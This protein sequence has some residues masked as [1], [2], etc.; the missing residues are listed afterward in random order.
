MSYLPEGC[1]RPDAATLEAFWQAARQQLSNAG[2]PNDYEVRW[3]G[4]DA[5]STTEI[6]ELI[7]AGDKTGTFTLPWIVARTDQPTPQV[8]AAIILIDFD[9][10]PTLLIRLTEIVEVPF[11][12]ITAEHTAVDGT[13]VRSLSVWKPMHTQYWN[14]MLSPF[15]MTVDDDMPVWIEKFE[16]LYP[17][18]T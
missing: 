8:G 9:G 2:L 10:Q 3:I 18:S 7:R 6:L 15:A 5:E 1:A 12:E 11:G 17:E 13:P 14:A 4:L 16:L